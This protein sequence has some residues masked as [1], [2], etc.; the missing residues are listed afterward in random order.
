VEVM[1][2]LGDIEEALGIAEKHNVKLSEDTALKL[3]PPAP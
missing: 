3:V 1:V 2:S